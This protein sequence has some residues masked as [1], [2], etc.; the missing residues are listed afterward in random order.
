MYEMFLHH[1]CV[2]RVEPSFGVEELGV[3]TED[4]LV[5]MDHPRVEAKHGLK[6]IRTRLVFRI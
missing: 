1:S 5:S 2:F 3:V 6:V 4:A